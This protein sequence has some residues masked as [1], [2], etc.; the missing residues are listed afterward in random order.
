MTE[1]DLAN[2][3]IE[4]LNSTQFELPEKSDDILA[5][6][7]KNIQIIKG[8]FTQLDDDSEV[9]WLHSKC[10]DILDLVYF[11]PGIL[12]KEIKLLAAAIVQAGLALLTDMDPKQVTPLT[13]R[14]MS[15]MHTVDERLGEIVG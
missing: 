6:V 1:N 15:A 2:A 5:Q 12:G 10:V 8:L 14:L 3:E 9:T 13:I 4:I 11:E 7:E